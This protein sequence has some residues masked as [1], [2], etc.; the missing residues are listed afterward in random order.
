M[1][2]GTK[3]SNEVFVDRLLSVEEV[4]ERTS[5]GRSTLWRL[6]KTGQLKSYKI[7]RSLRFKESD[8]RNFM[9]ELQVS[10]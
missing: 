10:K 7:G 6:V 2:I 8:L 1:Q 3:M 5:L 4:S 9:N